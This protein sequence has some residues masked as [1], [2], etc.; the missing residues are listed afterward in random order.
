MNT[1][2]VGKSFDERLLPNK[3]H[4]HNNLNMEGITDID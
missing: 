1:S 4:F 2:I 3:E